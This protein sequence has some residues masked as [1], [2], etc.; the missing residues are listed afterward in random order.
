MCRFRV[1]GE[2]RCDPQSRKMSQDQK[3]GLRAAF[4]REPK[5]TGE[6]VFGLGRGYGRELKGS[7]LG[8]A[9]PKVYISIRS[10]LVPSGFLLLLV[11]FFP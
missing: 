6:Q 7:A 11:C 8:H 9:R 2:A 3:E 1:T 5:Y 10:R 4:K